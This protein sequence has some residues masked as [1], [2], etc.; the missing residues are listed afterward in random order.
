MFNGLLATSYIDT[1]GNLKTSLKLEPRY[2]HAGELM[3]HVV[4][5][6]SDPQTTRAKIAAAG[7]PEFGS[8]DNLLNA[9]STVHR[10]INDNYDNATKLRQYWGYLANNVV[11]IQIS[12]DVS[13]ALKIFETINERGV[14]LDSMDLLKNLLFTQVKPQEF[15]RLKDE[16]KKVT[17]PLWKAK[18][19]PLRFLRYFLMANYKIKSDRRDAVVRED[20][21]YDWLIDRENAELCDYKTKPF[22]FGR[23]IIRNVEYFI[24]FTQGRTTDGETSSAMYNMQKLCGAAFSLHYVLCWRLAISPNRYL[25]ILLDN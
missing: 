16:W 14:G 5:I 3:K 2:E 6:D 9:Y 10:S 18:E 19:K 25:N 21:I 8:L 7:I 23:M 4:A 15:T 12:T 17:A 11:F 13:S 20:E 24:G 1:A 22:D